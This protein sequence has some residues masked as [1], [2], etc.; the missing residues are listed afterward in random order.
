VEIPFIKIEG[1]G[2]DY[3]FVD[4]KS[5]RSLKVSR[6]ALA[7]AISHRRFGVGSDGLIVLKKLDPQSASM[8]IFNS[9]GSEAEFC[10][11]GL[12]GTA[13]YLKFV[14]K[15]RGNE[16]TIF[17]RWNQYQAK[18]AKINGKSA[19]VKA[20]LG[21][22]IF[23]A[24]AVGFKGDNCLGI[25]LNPAGIPRKLYCMGMPNPHAVVF[26]ED[27][28]FDWQNEGMIIEK[29]P[30]FQRGIN[31]MFARIDSPKRVSLMPWERGSGPTMACGS[32]A[33]AVTVISNLLELTK[34][35][36]T[37]QMPGG[38]LLTRWNIADNQVT[39]EG[40]TRIAFSGIYSI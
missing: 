2:N 26:V 16:F 4:E 19:S 3:I 36:V 24:K 10:G 39:Q 30:L 1:L 22:P 32:G 14:Y 40:P 29:S 11:N 6:P 18:I 34:G 31:V 21:P 7:R 9:D 35:P 28:N 8:T 27:Y 23:E 17:T 20:S 37:V 38:T 12:R 25:D 13:L 15:A 5:L 33:A